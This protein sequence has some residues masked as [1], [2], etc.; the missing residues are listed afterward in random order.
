[1]A[2]SH[3]PS[4][5]GQ[6]SASWIAESMLA[7]SGLPIGESQRTVLIAGYAQLRAQINKLYDVQDYRDEVPALRFDANQKSTMW[8]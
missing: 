6:L 8:E 4:Y 5:S 2:D 3:V 7:A 1:M